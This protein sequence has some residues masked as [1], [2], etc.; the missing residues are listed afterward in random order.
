[1]VCLLTVFCLTLPFAHVQLHPFAA[2]IP[3]YGTTIV[4]INLITAA[5]LFS[6]F[7]VARWAWLLVLA[8]GFLF[9]A[10]SF[11]AFTLTFQGAIAPSGLLGAGPQTASWLGVCSRLVS[12]LFLIIAM[13]VRS[14]P[15]T[16]EKYQPAPE[17]AI[18]LSIALVTSIVCGLT[19]A[20]V[21]NAAVLPQVYPNGTQLPIN[22][23]PIVMALDVAALLLLWRRGQSVLELWLMVMC[24]TWLFQISLGGIFAGTSYSFGWY[25]AR[26][27]GL[28]SSL[29]VLLFF[30]S[31]NTA[32]YANLVQAAI[33]RRGARQARQIAM[34]A[35]AASI[36]HEIKQPL[37]ALITN[38]DAVLLMTKAKPELAEVHAVVSDMV[39]EGHRIGK[40]ISGIRTMFRESTHDRQPLNLNTVVR[41]V[42]STVDLEL[43]LQRL[44]VK[45][46]LESDLPSVLADSGQ[47]HQVFLNLITNAMEA[48][49]GVTGRPC[50]LTLTSGI[51][52]GASDIAVTVEDT[53]TGIA[54]N[55]SGRIFDPFFSTKAAGTGVGLTICR[56][57]V[58]GHG[59]KLEVHANK[60]CGTIFR[61]ILPTAGL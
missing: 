61:V 5:F 16:A 3:I 27:F 51:V 12:P 29:A 46:D 36:G 10:L 6:Q 55:D 37:S 43:R 39:T 15:E 2:F 26:V 22:N 58:E 56:V 59:G 7:M 30:L 8:S 48:M 11:V 45:T 47:L 49:T 19:W 24:V 42:L 50:V 33:Q 53:G 38:G 34:D 57:I 23:I 41:D 17:L 20:F 32:L 31:E 52:P 21:A 9:I 40:I 54:A 28:I 14:S 1:M 60:P 44:T 13:L 18:V 4:I 25:T 35:M